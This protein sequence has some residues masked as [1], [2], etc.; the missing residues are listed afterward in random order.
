MVMMSL[1]LP[2]KKRIIQK[3]E[4]RLNFCWGGECRGEGCYLN[5]HHVIINCGCVN[6]TGPQPFFFSKLTSLALEEDAGECFSD[7]KLG[8]RLCNGRNHREKN[9]WLDNI[10][11]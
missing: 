11:I 9:D 3:V 2:E 6:E 8:K 10:K 7:W 4:L 1:Q 5:P